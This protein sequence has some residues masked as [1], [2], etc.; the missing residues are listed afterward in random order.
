MDEGKGVASHGREQR[1]QRIGK[2]RSTR[3][4]MGISDSTYSN[5]SPS[6]LYL[7]LAS[8]LTLHPASRLKTSGAKVP[9][10]FAG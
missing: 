1:E 8:G 6:P 2:L 10:A 7:E 4:S 3:N 9:P 5:V